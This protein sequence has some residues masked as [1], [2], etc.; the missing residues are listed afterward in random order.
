MRLLTL[1]L[2]AIVLPLVTAARSFAGEVEHVPNCQSICATGTDQAPASFMQG[3]GPKGG[4]MGKQ[5]VS[6]YLG[7]QSAAY[8]AATGPAGAS[9]VFGAKGQVH[10]DAQAV[11]H[12]HTSAATAPGC[13]AQGAGVAHGPKGGY[14]VPKGTSA[15]LGAQ[16]CAAQCGNACPQ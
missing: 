14:L 3:F 6:P 13:D 7:N 11:V 16:S 9:P 10:W 1:S 2:I 8:L 5:I 15:W 4:L 12:E